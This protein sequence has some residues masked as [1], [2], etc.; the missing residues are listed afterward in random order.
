[1]AINAIYEVLSLLFLSYYNLKRLKALLIISI[2]D[3]I[4]WRELTKK[5]GSTGLSVLFAVDELLT[6]PLMLTKKLDEQI[7]A[8]SLQKEGFK[9]ERSVVRGNPKTV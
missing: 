9:T 4:L 6:A 5:V 1:M 7:K 2:L 3:G 8:L